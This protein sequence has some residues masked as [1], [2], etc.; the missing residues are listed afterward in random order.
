MAVSTEEKSGAKPE[1][2]YKIIYIFEN[3]TFALHVS[4]LRIPRT[5]KIL[6]WAE[7]SAH[8][9]GF[10]RSARAACGT[11]R[12]LGFSG[13]GVSTYRGIRGANLSSRSAGQLMLQ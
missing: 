4:A 12:C 13:T 1:F 6:D 2:F 10:I 11:L 8:I 3:G 5:V 9:P 7:L